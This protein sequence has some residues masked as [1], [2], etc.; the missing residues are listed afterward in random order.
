MKA[1]VFITTYDGKMYT[2]PSKI[3]VP[4]NTNT[5]NFYRILE[6]DI[7]SAKKNDLK[8]QQ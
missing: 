3:K 4:R 8:K 1:K 2:D 5:E 7:L 6:N